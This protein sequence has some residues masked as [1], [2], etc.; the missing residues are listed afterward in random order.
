[1]SLLCCRSPRL[2]PRAEQGS[3]AA[4]GLLPRS[5]PLQRSEAF[6]SG[7]YWNLSG[8]LYHPTL[9]MLQVTCRYFHVHLRLLAFTPPIYEMMLSDPSPTLNLTVPP[10]LN[11]TLKIHECL[12]GSL[13]YHPCSSS[14]ARK[15]SAG[16]RLTCAACSASH[17]R[18]ASTSTSLAAIQSG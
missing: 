17:Q 15:A 5:G 7:K 9:H 3:P 16:L 11:L 18:T 13:G 12:H 14:L 8:C 1:M 6:C 4:R 10:T 2:S